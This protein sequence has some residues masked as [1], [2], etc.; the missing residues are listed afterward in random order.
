MARPL[1][2]FQANQLVSQAFKA[3]GKPLD[4]N[5]TV[6]S[7]DRQGNI[8][9]DFSNDGTPDLRLEAVV[10]GGK[11]QTKVI[12]SG[13]SGGGETWAENGAT[14]PDEAYGIYGTLNP[15]NQNDQLKNYSTSKKI[16]YYPI[17]IYQVFPSS[18]T[19]Q[20]E[21]DKADVAQRLQVVN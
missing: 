7:S 10:K 8:L 21:I 14:F 17:N 15:C 9:V 5:N 18:K 20:R 3:I 11:L 12:L 13:C 1:S 16:T 6:I 2:S 19:P 4:P